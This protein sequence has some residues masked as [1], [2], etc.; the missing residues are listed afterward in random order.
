MHERDDCRFQIVTTPW[1]RR[2]TDPHPLIRFQLRTGL[3]PTEDYRYTALCMVCAYRGRSQ[4]G[5]PPSAC[6][7]SARADT[8]EQRMAEIGIGDPVNQF[9]RAE[10][11]ES[12]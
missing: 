11:L 3:N 1:K 4:S 10:R 6:S 8:A 5:L 2:A 9:Y 7:A 12:R